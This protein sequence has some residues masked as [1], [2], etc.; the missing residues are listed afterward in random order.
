MCR[1][2]GRGETSAMT[3][4]ITLITLTVLFTLALR[5]PRADQPS[6][7]AGYDGERQLAELRALITTTTTERPSDIPGRTEQADPSSA[8]R[9]TPTAPERRPS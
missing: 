5:R 9:R 2:L 6:L 4:W 8:P 3:A 7:P 1:G